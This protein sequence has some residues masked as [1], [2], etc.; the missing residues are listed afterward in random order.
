MVKDRG[1]PE[2]FL[3][4]PTVDGLKVT[5]WYSVDGE[6]YTEIKDVKAEGVG[7]YY[8]YDPSR[9]GADKGYAKQIRLTF[10]D[11]D[12]RWLMIGV[13][14][15]ADDNNGF[16]SIAYSKG[17]LYCAY[18]ENPKTGDTLSIVALGTV[19]AVAGIVIVSKKKKNV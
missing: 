12:A 17:K 18:E 11:V 15:P 14:T 6:N 13:E 19:A 2:K 10:D 8:E 16:V 5:Y 1:A 7:D 4:G 3:A 9:N